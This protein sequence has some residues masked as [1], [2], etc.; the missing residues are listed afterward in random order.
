MARA[1]M[2][3][4]SRHDNKLEEWLMGSFI[5]MLIRCKVP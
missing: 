4:A 3:G 2:C 5:M 1:L